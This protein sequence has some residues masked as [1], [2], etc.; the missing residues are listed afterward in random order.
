M[1]PSTCFALL[2]ALAGTILVEAGQAQPPG[3]R[4]EEFFDD[5]VL[6]EIRLDMHSRDWELL[7]ERFLEN[8]YYPAE[9]RWR[10]QRVRNIGIRSRGTG[11]R[12]G[13]KPA[14]RVDFDRYSTSQTFLGLKS[15]ILRNNV[16]DPSNLHERL[17]MLLFRRLGIPASREAHTRLYVNDEYVGLYSIVES[18]DKG[19]LRRTFDQDEGY[20]YD[21]DYPADAAPY[22]FEYRGDDPQRYVPLPFKPETHEKAP[23]PEVIERLI[24]AI[25]ETNDEE[26]RGA[27][28]EYLDLNAFVRH[29]AV[30]TFLADKDGI[31]GDYGANNFYLYRFRD[32]RFFTIIPW[33]KSEA[34]KGGFDYSIFHNLS[35]V[36]SWLQNR[37]MRRALR[38]R[39]LYDLYLATQLE[40]AKSVEE[41]AGNDPRGWLE[42]EIEREYSQIRDAVWDDPVKPYPFGEFEQA[43][44]DLVAFSR[45]RGEFVRSEVNGAAGRPF[46]LPARRESRVGP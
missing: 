32:S 36:P 38:Y 18:I 45:Y 25:N 8:E 2:F 39:D 10:D 44:N 42:R 37:L 19:F 6:H 34:F 17:S 15:V 4:M 21:Y 11:S 46:L 29:I 5:S 7:K 33:D 20:L 9:F 22:Y 24:W 14:L 23:Q 1:K 31:L 12:S 28:G 30:E 13:T 27:I 35:D 40:I 16:Q 3:P 26:F 41:P 43:I